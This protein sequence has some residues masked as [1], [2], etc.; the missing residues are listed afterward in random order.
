MSYIYCGWDGLDAD[1]EASVATIIS[2]IPRLGKE[3][4][5]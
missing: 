3:L 5:S 2:L 4:G 1:Q